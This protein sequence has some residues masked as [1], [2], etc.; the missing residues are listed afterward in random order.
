M[1][2]EKIFVYYK[3]RKE[4]VGIINFYSTYSKKKIIKCPD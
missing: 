2:I 1:K 4:Y 3:N